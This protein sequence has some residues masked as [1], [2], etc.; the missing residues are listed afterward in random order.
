[1][2]RLTPLM[3]PA[4][5]PS[6]LRCGFALLSGVALISV[7]LAAPVA[8]STIFFDDFATDS[9]ATSY[10]TSTGRNAFNYSVANE[11]LAPSTAGQVSALTRNTSIGSFSTWDGFTLSIDFLTNTSLATAGNVNAA[12]LAFATADNTAY[13]GSSF[14]G[15]EVTV[16]QESSDP[17]N[18]YYLRMR[19]GAGTGIVNSGKIALAANTWHTLTLSVSANEA[20]NSFTVDAMIATQAAPSVALTGIA[21][22]VFSYTLAKDTALFAGFAGL[23][24][25]GRGAVALDNF[26]VTAIPEPSA[27]AV[28]FGAL[29]LTAVG[30]RRRRV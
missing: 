13:S 25:T 20:E 15:F 5:A 28:I 16:R 24:N 14:T 10:N 19:D 22:H 1:M 29:A 30:Y 7:F 3:N 23:F 21:S 18:N 12:A 8:A 4:P 26:S 9:R 27:A 2:T 11:R 6:R 17:A